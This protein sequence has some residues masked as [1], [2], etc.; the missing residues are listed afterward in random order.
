M[1]MWAGPRTVAR[2]QDG[3]LPEHFMCG[4]ALTIE[5][6]DFFQLLSFAGVPASCGNFAAT[7]DLAFF[8]PD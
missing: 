7:K 1:L 2:R 3:K 6:S 4:T 5:A 8:I